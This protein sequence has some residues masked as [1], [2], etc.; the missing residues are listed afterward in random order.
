MWLG[1]V[2]ADVAMTWF[3]RRT[4]PQSPSH[5][6]AMYTGGN[7]GMLGGHVGLCE[8][9]GQLPS[10]SPSSALLF[11]VSVMTC[12]HGRRGC[13]LGT[14]MSEVRGTYTALG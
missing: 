2:A 13:L 4:S 14:W 8:C 1:M 11:S 12:R 7:L 9:R 6:L 5:T 3:L 10:A